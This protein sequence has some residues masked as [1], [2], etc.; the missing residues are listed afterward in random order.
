M[1]EPLIEFNK[2]YEYERYLEETKTQGTPTKGSIIKS[3]VFYVV[4]I[5]AVLFSFLW[6]SND[7][8]GKK[9]GPF[10]YSTVLTSSMQSVYPQGSLV[11]SWSVKPNEPLQAGLTNGD[12]IVFTTEEGMV[13]VHRII[14][15]LDDYE[16]SGQRAFK[17]QGVENPAPDNFITYEG[18]I[19]GKVTW[20]VPYVGDILAFISEN[21]IWFV[22]GIAILFALSALFNVVFA[23][24][25]QKTKKLES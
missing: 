20:H 11:T 17:T 5:S 18:N 15:V 4:L 10:A 19:I 13:I 24:E 2:K 22:A 16:D 14:E 12:D 8:A 23:K 1:P 9:F 7:D 21:I 3:T 6:S 25:E